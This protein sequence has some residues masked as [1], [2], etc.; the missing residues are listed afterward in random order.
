[1]T[2]VLN[3]ACALGAG[4]AIAGFYFADPPHLVCARGIMILGC[5]IFIGAAPIQMRNLR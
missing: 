4:M 2:R 5:A 3:V 1:M